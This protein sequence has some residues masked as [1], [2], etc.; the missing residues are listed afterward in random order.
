MAKLAAFNN[1]ENV[2]A[3]HAPR[4]SAWSRSWKLVIQLESLPVVPIIAI[5]ILM[6]QLTVADSKD[7]W[8]PIYC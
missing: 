7:L 2:K 4:D 8:I 5:P 6:N 3:V 1:K